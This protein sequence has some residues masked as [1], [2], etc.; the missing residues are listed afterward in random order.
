M[1]SQPIE[2]KEDGLIL[3]ELT[4]DE[5]ALI[6]RHR[7]IYSEVKEGVTFSEKPAYLETTVETP[8]KLIKLKYS[9]LTTK[10]QDIP[11]KRNPNKISFGKWSD[12]RNRLE[13]ATYRNSVG[14]SWFVFLN[15]EKITLSKWQWKSFVST[16]M[17]IGHYFRVIYPKGRKKRRKK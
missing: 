13:F 11:K 10:I 6:N 3:V 15:G 12:G 14:Q 2:E 1:T 5:L 16:I 8:D 7:A 17:K 9:P 4:L